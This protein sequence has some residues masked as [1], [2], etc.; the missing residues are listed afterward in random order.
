MKIHSFLFLLSVLLS[1]MLSCSRKDNKS[2]FSGLKD[3]VDSVHIQYVP[4]ERDDVYDISVLQRDGKPVLRGITS[5]AEAKSELLDRARKIHPEVMDSIQ[6]L[7]DERLKDRIYAVANVSVADLRTDASYAAEMA[8]QLLLGMPMQILQNGQGWYRVKTP[9]DYVAWVSKGTVIRMDREKFRQWETAPKVIFTDDYGFAYETPDENR[10]RASDLVF[11]NLLKWE[12]DN[13]RFYRVAYPDGRQAYVLKSQSR[14][15][16]DWKA[17]IQLTGKSIVETALALKGI[18]YS[19]GGTSVKAMDCS[20]FTKT[21]YLKHGIVLKRDA[22]QQAKTGIPVDISEGYEHLRPGDLLFFGKKRVRH[23]AIYI[24]N[25]EFIHA[26][27][28]VHVSSLDPKQPHYDAGNTTE[29]LSARRILGSLYTSRASIKFFLNA[30]T[31][32]SL[33]T[34]DANNADFHGFYFLDH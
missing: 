29:L 6:I 24:G 17:S 34:S 27:G 16:S 21:V 26:A 4:D 20:G 19:W 14:M 2:A 1:G 5:V 32:T 33:I 12:G 15:F 28:Y 3:L 10:Q 18:P 7:S 30:D 23:V 31:S 8:T 9:E 22:S 25:Q 13:G 11:G